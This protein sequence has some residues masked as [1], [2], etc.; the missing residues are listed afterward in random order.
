MRKWLIVAGALVLAASVVVALWGVTRWE[1]SR[2]FKSPFDAVAVMCGPGLADLDPGFSGG[3]SN[4]YYVG[5]D[6]V[7]RFILARPD[8]SGI[9][10]LVKRTGDRGFTVEDCNLPLPR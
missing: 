8:R 10:A 9:G 5:T 6:G 3:G 2:P 7:P 4:T 1:G